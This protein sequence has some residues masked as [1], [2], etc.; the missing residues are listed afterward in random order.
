MN[1]FSPTGTIT[2]RMTST[3]TRKEPLQVISL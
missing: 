1:T 2:N 3:I